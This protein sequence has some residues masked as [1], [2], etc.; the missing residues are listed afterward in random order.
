MNTR[1]FKTRNGSELSFTTMGMGMGPIGEIYEVLDE[2]TTIATVEQAY[3]SGIRLFDTSPHYGNGIAESR[4]G[5]GLRRARRSEV[6]VSTKIGR[7]MDPFAKPP[8]RNT[9]TTM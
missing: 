2:K 5:A 9:T 4:L 8:P 6:I 3:R 1:Q 7:V